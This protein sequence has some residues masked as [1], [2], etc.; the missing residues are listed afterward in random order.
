VEV[1]ASRCAAR[2]SMASVLARLACR[3]NSMRASIAPLAL[4]TPL[5]LHGPQRSGAAALP[6]ASAAAR[7]LCMGPPAAKPPAPAPLS[8]NAD[9]TQ[10][11]RRG[12][13]RGRL[14][15]RQWR[16]GDGGSPYAVPMPWLGAYY[17]LRADDPAAVR[18]RDKLAGRKSP[19]RGRFIVDT[20]NKQEVA[21]LQASEPWRKGE[22]KTGDYLEVRHR[23]S[24]SEPVEQYVGLVLGRHNKGLGSSF[25]LLTKPDGLP[26]E[27]QFFLHSPLLAGINVVG[28]THKK[29]RSNKIY[30]M[31][32]KVN[33]VVIPKVRPLPREKK[34]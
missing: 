18:K 14:A 13:R 12:S 30:H 28:R 24:M 16:W 15:Q 2:P 31:R 23:P 5:A 1:P 32:D 34:S 25:R 33:E 21:R 11:E 20:L 26:V 3:S 9:A 8:G 27:Y 22:F 4:R 10:G 17:S 7:F 6:A 29:V 19:S